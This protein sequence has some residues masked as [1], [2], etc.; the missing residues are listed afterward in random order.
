MSNYKI[1]EY[2]RKK[3]KLH[4]VIVKPSENPKKKIDVFDKDGEKLASVGV[5][6][7]KD[8]PTYIQTIGKRGADE[9]RRLYR[10]RHR[11]DPMR[12]NGERTPAFFAWNLLW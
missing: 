10:L 6:G 3:A 11:N 4:G 7:Y 12:D 8:Y 1:T 5:V 9:R 2:T